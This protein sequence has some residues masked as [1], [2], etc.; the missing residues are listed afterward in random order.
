MHRRCACRLRLATALQNTNKELGTIAGALTT[1]SVE[2]ED[3]GAAAQSAK[4]ASDV[5]ETTFADAEIDDILGTTDGPTL[6]LREL[7]GLDR[8]MQTVRGELVNNLAKLSGLD[9]DIAAQKRKL[10]EAGDEFTRR[11]VAERLRNLE[12]ERAS[13]L[14]AATANREALRDQVNRIRETIGQVLNEDTTLAESIRTLLREQG[15]TIASILT[16]I[17][18]A[19][20]TLVLALTG[21]GGSPAP[22]PPAPSDKGGLKE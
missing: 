16:A 1:E 14:E 2:L 15:I 17:G 12:D 19:I 5:V 6:N 22:T 9:S 8:A 11:R 4:R 20:S 18:M 3:L 10:D 21:G 7:R 13:R